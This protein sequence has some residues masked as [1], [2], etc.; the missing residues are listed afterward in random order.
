MLNGIGRRQIDYTSNR[1]HLSDRVLDVGRSLLQREWIKIH[2]STLK[3]GPS[4]DQSPT[5]SDQNTAN[6]RC[7]A[8]HQA[9][10]R[11]TDEQ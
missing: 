11:C 1:S 6:P 8:Y 3:L 2:F 5:F 9:V 10:S 7:I 4:L